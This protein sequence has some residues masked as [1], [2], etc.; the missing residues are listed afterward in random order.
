MYLYIYIGEICIHISVHIN[1]NKLYIRIVSRIA[2]DKTQLEKKKL[3]I[4]AIDQH[5]RLNEQ[6]ASI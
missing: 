4:P 2:Y 1:N 3:I 6:H 5:L